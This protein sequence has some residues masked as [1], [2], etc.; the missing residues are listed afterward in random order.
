M[1]AQG[2]HLRLHVGDVLARPHRRR[3]VLLDRGILGRQAKRIQPMGMRT[4]KPFMRM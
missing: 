1:P 3:D 4:L 2:L